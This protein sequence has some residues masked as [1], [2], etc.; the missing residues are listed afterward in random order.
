[1]ELCMGV[2]VQ[3]SGQEVLEQRSPVKKMDTWF[4]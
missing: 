4:W 3:P 2:Q 1:M